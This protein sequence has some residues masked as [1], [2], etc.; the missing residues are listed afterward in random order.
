MA[1]SMI[2]R[3][4]EAR[5]LC[6]DSHE[7]HLELLG[8][9]AGDE[10]MWRVEM[11]AGELGAAEAHAQRSRGKLAELGDLS[12]GSTAAVQWALTCYG[13]GRFED[14]RRL[15]R[16]CRDTGASDDVVN[17]YLWRCVEAGVLAHEDRLEEADRLIDE[18]VDWVERTDALLDQATVYG[19]RAEISARLGRSDDAQ[20]A[21][22]KARGAA[23]RKGATVV[24]EQV[25]RQAAELGLT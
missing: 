2:G 20:A 25:D 8:F 23:V 18:A 22:A 15:A 17:Q 6:R 10:D 24:V 14:A 13:L 3:F 7:L 16:E 4:D 12:Y 5:G 1:L 9:E 19:F 21:L 11:L